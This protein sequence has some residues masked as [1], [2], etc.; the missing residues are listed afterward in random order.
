MQIYWS[1]FAF[2]SLIEIIAWYKV[3]AGDNVANAIKKRINK[4]ISLYNEPLLNPNS[5][6]NSELLPE[7]KKLVIRNLPYIAYLHEDSNG[8][9]EIVD[10]VHTSRKLP[11]CRDTMR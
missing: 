6:H 3:E 4:Q 7:Y 1:D 11:K 10:I 8:D 5:L 9:W 2:D